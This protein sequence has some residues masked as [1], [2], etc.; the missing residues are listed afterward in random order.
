[1][2]R[3]RAG[4]WL[5][6]VGAVGLLVVL[7]LDWF[8]LDAGGSASGWS[9]LGRL[10]D[11]FLALIIVGGLAMA[12]TTIRRSAPAMPVGSAVLTFAV[13]TLT[14]LALLIRVLTKSDAGQ[15]AW[16]YVG[17]VLA[18]LMPAG[19]FVT[20]KDERTGA[21]ESAYTPPPAR[22]VPGG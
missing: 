15:E 3:L 16:A 1:V 19:A 2:S 6:L 9:G 5:A 22:P 20:L 17:L 7:F 21:P 14:W 10:M 11:V 12:F 13:G 4:E 18:A 8:D